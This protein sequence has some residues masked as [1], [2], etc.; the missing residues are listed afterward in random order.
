MGIVVMVTP[1]VT[2]T[3]LPRPSL[4]VILAVP[5][6]PAAVTVNWEVEEA[7]TVATF[8]L[9]TL[10]VKLPVYP[11]SVTA[12]VAVWPAPVKDNA[13]GDAVNVGGIVIGML[14]PLP[15]SVE[16]TAVWPSESVTVNV[17]EPL[18]TA[19]AVKVVPD[20]GETLVI[21]VFALLT[22]KVPL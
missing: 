13:D 17:V 18:A 7:V 5:G 9:S 21:V 19:L 22:V 6:L 12:N 1:T 8:A 14:P 4:T 16:K 3:E 2:V 10:A 15:S 20:D 11:V